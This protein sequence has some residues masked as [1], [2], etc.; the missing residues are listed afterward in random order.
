M[1]PLAKWLWLAYSWHKIS[2]HKFWF[3]SNNKYENTHSE[4]YSLM[5]NQIMSCLFH[6]KAC[7]HSLWFVN[8]QCPLSFSKC[9]MLL[10]FLHPPS[11]FQ[12][13]TAKPF[14]FEVVHLGLTAIMEYWFPDQ[15]SRRWVVAMVIIK[16][17]RTGFATFIATVV[18][19]E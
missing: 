5:L 7:S 13:L 4:I 15:A 11:K 18:D 12:P 17:S 14:H 10:S 3:F 19:S 8:V 6:S 16:W 9:H 1:F 2:Q